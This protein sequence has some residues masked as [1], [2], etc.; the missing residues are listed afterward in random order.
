MSFHIG[1]ESFD[2]A[3]D[4]TPYL[5]LRVRE[6]AEAAVR[7]QSLAATLIHVALATA[8]AEQ[9]CNAGDRAWIAANRVW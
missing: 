4:D 2:S 7:A 6:E 1:D 9:C 5:S 8:Y 3:P